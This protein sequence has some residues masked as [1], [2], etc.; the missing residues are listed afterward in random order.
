MRLKPGD[1]EMGYLIDAR[2]DNG[3]P[4]LQILDVESGAVRMAWESREDVG[5]DQ[6]EL[7]RLFW[8]LFL[9]SL[10]QRWSNEKRQ[11]DQDHGDHAPIP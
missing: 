4:R 1:R 7:K 8:G 10:Q 5:Q 9:L 11:V 3:R 6:A 2:L